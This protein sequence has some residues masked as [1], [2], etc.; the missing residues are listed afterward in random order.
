MGKGK[1]YSDF[2]FDA[3]SS[4]GWISTLLAISGKVCQTNL[5]P[6]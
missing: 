6:E 5:V 2:N 1:G 3:K 4:N